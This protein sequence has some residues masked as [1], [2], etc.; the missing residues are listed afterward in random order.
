MFA[1]KWQEGT[2]PEVGVN[3]AQVDEVVGACIDRLTV[4][5]AELPD[6][7]TSLAITKLEEAFMWLQRRTEKR[8]AQGVEGTRSPHV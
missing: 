4:L 7:E 6:R 8:M 5:R 3:G 2:V 1:I